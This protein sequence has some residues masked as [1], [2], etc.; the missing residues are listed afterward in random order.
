MR[1]RLAVRESGVLLH[2]TSLPGAYGVGDLGPEAFRFAHQLGAAGQSWWQVLPLGPPGEDDSPYMA[3]SA[4]MNRP[5]TSAGNWAWRL[6]P[7]ALTTDVLRR[8]GDLT[9]IYGRAPE[10]VRP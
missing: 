6:S 3:S 8:L 5:G 7:E 9:E 4:R 10:R 2:P 1:K